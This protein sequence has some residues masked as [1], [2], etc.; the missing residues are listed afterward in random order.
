MS[1]IFLRMFADLQSEDWFPR[2]KL[3]IFDTKIQNSFTSV[4]KFGVSKIFEKLFIQKRCVKLMKG[5]S[6]FVTKYLY[7]K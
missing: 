3:Y 6:K 4:L 1:V 2:H 7:F 5:D